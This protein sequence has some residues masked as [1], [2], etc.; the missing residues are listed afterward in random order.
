MAWGLGFFQFV[1][2]CF[3]I[4]FVA[5]EDLLL[6]SDASFDYLFR[7]VPLGKFGFVPF[8]FEVSGLGSPAE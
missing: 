6:G 8:C 7:F 3:G 4:G 5:C 2:V 1:F